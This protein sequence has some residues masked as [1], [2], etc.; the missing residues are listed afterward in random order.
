MLATAIAIA[1]SAIAADDEETFGD[2]V[3]HFFGNLLPPS[4]K[5]KK[6]AKETAN[7]FSVTK[8]LD[9]AGT[10][11]SRRGRIGRNGD[12]DPFGSCH[13]DAWAERD[14]LD[15]GSFRL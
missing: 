15:G 13:P 6:S 8:S 10:K 3:K 7:A 14:D 9:I 1:G 5:R 12:A 11:P 2:K 4:K